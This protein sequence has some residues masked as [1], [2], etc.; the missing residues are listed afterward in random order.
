[1]RL[2]SRADEGS[3]RVSKPLGGDRRVGYDERTFDR[4]TAS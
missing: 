4:L 3:E 2:A 1:M